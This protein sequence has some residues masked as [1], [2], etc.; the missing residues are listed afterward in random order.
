L[1]IINA[2]RFASYIAISDELRRK[3]QRSV[4]VEEA[5]LCAQ[6]TSEIHVYADGPNAAFL[7][8]G[9]D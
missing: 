5:I 1:Q 4:S 3:M 2:H 9:E 6:S 7:W 8:Q